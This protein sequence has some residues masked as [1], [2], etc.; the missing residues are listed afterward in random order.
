MKYL[1]IGLSFLIIFLSGCDDSQKTGSEKRNKV[2]IISGVPFFMPTIKGF[3]ERMGEIGYVEGEN[4]EY[5]LKQANGDMSKMRQGAKEFAKNGVDLIF[6]TTNGG[7][8]AAKEA[9]KDNDVPVVFTIVMA[10]V[11]S[12]LVDSLTS[13]SGNITG[14]RNPLGEFIGK[15]LD[16]LNQMAPKAKNILLFSKPD[17]PTIPVALR[18]LRL[19]ATKLDMRLFNVSISK[20]SDVKSY[21][22][23]AD[24]QRIDAIFVMPDPVAQSKETLDYIFKFSV[25]HRIPVVA[26]TPRQA[27]AG[28]L[29]SYLSDSTE[30]GREAATIA[31]R[32]LGGGGRGLTH[33]IISSEPRLIINLAVAEKI[34]LKIDNSLIALA[35]ETISVAK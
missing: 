21:L 24:P 16:L 31:H 14:V 33:P 12:G 1:K 10:P 7:A 17:Y 25:L 30:T 15:R 35:H 29:F 22:L 32:I 18:Q 27:E 20:P 9:T 4:I 23:D 8:L 26:N 34:G 28:A 2:G 6:T 19:A 11:E 13:P 5:F 3:K